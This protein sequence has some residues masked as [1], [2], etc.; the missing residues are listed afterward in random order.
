MSE[1]Q[2]S[3][4]YDLEER[5]EGFA[6][7]AGAFVEKLPK[8]MTNLE[9][10]RQ[11]IRSTGS[12]GSNYIE[13]NEALSKKDLIMRIKICRKEAKESAYWLRL[14][15][16]QDSEKEEQRQLIQEATELTKIFGAILTKSE[17]K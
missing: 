10:G 16:C 3:K 1:K 4:R 6:R 8:T 9:Y 13:A 15:R 12:V 5:T 14:V 2:I 7:R 11:L 17:H